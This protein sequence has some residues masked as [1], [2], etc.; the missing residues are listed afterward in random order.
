MISRDV[1]LNEETRWD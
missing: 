1:K